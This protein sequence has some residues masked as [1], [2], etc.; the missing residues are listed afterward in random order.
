[1]PTSFKT[2]IDFLI[3]DT[4]LFDLSDISVAVIYLFFLINAIIA[5][6]VSE[7]RIVESM[8]ELLV[9]LMV[10]LWWKFRSGKTILKKV[11]RLKDFKV[12]S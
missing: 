1:M 12:L 9:E 8:V 6:C 2:L 11:Y 7:R 3:V 10:E 5:T 4:S